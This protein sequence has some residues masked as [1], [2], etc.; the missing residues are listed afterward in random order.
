[1]DKMADYLDPD[2]ELLTRYIGV[3]ISK[4]LKGD[5]L[6]KK[7]SIEAITRRHERS[8][9]V[10]PSS[11]GAPDL[12][13]RAVGAFVR[14]LARRPEV[15]SY[16][17]AVTGRNDLRA[18]LLCDAILSA[19]PETPVPAALGEGKMLTALLEL[20]AALTRAAPG[21]SLRE[22]VERLKAQL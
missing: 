4:D 14:D 21:W 17:S 5:Q 15:Q 10:P 13:D 19:M 6:F 8:N 11:G 2:L 12:Y 16:F 22:H 20:L 18:A 9:T 3:Y 7:G 1:L